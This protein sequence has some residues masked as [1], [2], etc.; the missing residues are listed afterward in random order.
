MQAAVPRAQGRL[1]RRDQ[2]ADPRERPRPAALAHH[3]RQPSGAALLAVAV[4]DVGQLLLRTPVEQVGRRRA[5]RAVEA[6]VQRPLLPEREAPLRRRELVRREAEIEQH[7][8]ARPEA[9]RRRHALDRS[10]AAVDQRH[11]CPERREALAGPRDRRRVGVQPEHRSIRRACLQQ[12]GGVPAAAHGPVHV[13]PARAG[14]QRFQDL[15][16]HDRDVQAA[17]VPPVGR[18]SS[19]SPCTCSGPRSRKSLRERSQAA[20]SQISMRS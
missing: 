17:H 19:A 1:D 11:A 15:V 18:S 3:P 16:Q 12:R 7:A 4:E 5:R 9:V 2:V 20:R 14:L 8:V 13:A 10:K 6:H